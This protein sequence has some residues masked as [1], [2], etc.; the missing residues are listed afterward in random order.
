MQADQASIP[1]MGA[2]ATVTASNT[3]TNVSSTLTTSPLMKFLKDSTAGTIGGIAV[4]LVG[5]PFGK[6]KANQCF[7]N[8]LHPSL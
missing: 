1:A 8:Q 5:H 3:A 4:T 7:H 2:G 6:W